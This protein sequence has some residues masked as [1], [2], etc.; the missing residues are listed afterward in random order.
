MGVQEDK[1]KQ[2]KKKASIMLFKIFAVLF[3]ASSLQQ[4][5]AEDDLCWCICPYQDNPIYKYL[6]N[7]KN[8]CPNEDYCYVSCNSDCRDKRPGPAANTCISEIACDMDIPPDCPEGWADFDSE[9]YK[10]FQSIKSWQDAENYCQGEGGHLASIH[11]E[12]ENNFVAGLDSDSMWLG[13]T[14]VTTEGSWVWSDGSTFSF[15][16]WNPGQPDNLFY[17]GMPEQDC[18]RTN[19]EPRFGGSAGKWDD[20]QCNLTSYYFKFVCK[21][22]AA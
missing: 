8:T 5:S 18:L 7:P 9:C 2:T 21:K 1:V 13:G 19:F 10:V 20:H 12:E 11:S 16:S 17:G 22:S 6:C 3:L 15:N 4:I 14:D